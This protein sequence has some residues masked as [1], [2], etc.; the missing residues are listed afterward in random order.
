MAV[1]CFMARSCSPDQRWRLALLLLPV[2]LARLLLL[3][4]LLLVLLVLLLTGLLAGLL[5]RLLVHLVAAGL[6]LVA[7]LC[8]GDNSL[9]IL[10]RP[11][12]CHGFMVAPHARPGCRRCQTPCFKT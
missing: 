9:R 7:L 1:C 5:A 8:H 3:R 12:A 11:R 2:L 10:A 4:R 6:L